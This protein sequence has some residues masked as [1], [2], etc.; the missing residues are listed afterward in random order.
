MTTVPTAHAVVALMQLLGEV[1]ELTDRLASAPAAA[2]EILGEHRLR[3]RLAEH[4]SRLAAIADPTRFLDELER[5]E[6]GAWLH[7]PTLY[8]RAISE[9][10]PAEARRLLR[11]VEP[12]ARLFATVQAEHDAAVR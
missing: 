7:D 6:L 1:S 11:A 3:L 2:D 5:S 12:A 4:A 10:G 8:R 9:S